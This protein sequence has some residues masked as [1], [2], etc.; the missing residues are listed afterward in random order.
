MMKSI[1]ASNGL[2]RKGIK[3]L[4]MT[5]LSR[6]YAEIFEIY[7]NITSSSKD[8]NSVQINDLNIFSG[9]RSGGL[10]PIISTRE[11]RKQPIIE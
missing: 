6:D 8:E 3:P 5:V 10:Y 9:Y 11:H 7:Q 4:D 2:N 1:S